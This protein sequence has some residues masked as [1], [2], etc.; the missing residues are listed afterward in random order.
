MLG[1]RRPLAAAL[2]AAAGATLALSAPAGADV[3]SVSDSRG[4]VMSYYPNVPE[5]VVSDRKSDIRSFKTNYR[6]QKII[7]RTRFWA[8]PD[9]YENSDNALRMLWLVKTPDELYYVG[10]VFESAGTGIQIATEADGVFAC[11]GMQQYVNP[12]DASFRMVIPR[13]CVGR[14]K[15]IRTN[16][17]SAHWYAHDESD[18]DDNEIRCDVARAP[19]AVSCYEEARRLGPRIHYDT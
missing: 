7:L 16:S 19:Q 18:P 9:D 4:D 2:A 10:A 13:E 15:W 6:D 11:E 1:V 8:Y 14:P 17:F 5:T 3:E 12:D